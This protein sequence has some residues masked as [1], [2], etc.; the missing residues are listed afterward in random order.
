MICLVYVSAATKLFDPATL[1]EL[2]AVSQRNNAAADI[3]GMLMYADGNILQTL[4]GEATAVDRLFSRIERDPR[5]NQLFKLYQRPIERRQFGRWSMALARPDSLGE[6][7]GLESLA[8]MRKSLSMP[9][10]SK[11]ANDV[12]MLLKLF[13][14]N[15]R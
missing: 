12:R 13:A 5:H 2:L 4:E 15:M 6:A 14:D 10:D 1:A 3:T 8:L 7:E 11:V 9:G